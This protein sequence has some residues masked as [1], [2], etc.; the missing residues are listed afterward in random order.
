MPEVMHPFTKVVSDSGTWILA[1][2]AFAI[3]AILALVITKVWS[4][5]PSWL[6]KW[7][8]GILPVTVLIVA[9]VYSGTVLR[10]GRFKEDIAFFA[11][12][13]VAFSL[14]L[15]LLAGVAGATGAPAPGAVA[16]GCSLTPGVGSRSCPRASSAS[17]G[18]SGR[19]GESLGRTGGFLPPR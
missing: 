9:I 10:L 8:A 4:D 16:P 11:K 6:A 2:G 19:A 3:S 18:A 17:R 1:A 12:P 7:G 5:T 13:E 14:L 15:L